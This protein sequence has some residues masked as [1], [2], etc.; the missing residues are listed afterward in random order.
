[1]AEAVIEMRMR[2]ADPRSQRSRQLLRAAAVRLLRRGSDPQPSVSTLVRTA[3]VSRSTFYAHY[4]SVDDLL[5][6]A[7]GELSLFVVPAARGP[8]GFVRG[9]FEQ[10][11]QH[12]ELASAMLSPERHTDLAPRLRHQIARSLASGGHENCGLAGEVLADGVVAALRWWLDV[13]PERPASEMSDEFVRLWS[14][15]LAAY[16]GG[17]GGHALD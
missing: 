3:Q 10:V 14:P 7:L 12:R 11:E 8:L 17:F 15:G 9:L 13:C 4:D 16:C 5:D 6:D 1:M 2:G